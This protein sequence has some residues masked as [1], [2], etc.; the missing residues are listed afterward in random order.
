MKRAIIIVVDSLGVGYM[1]DV[2][3]TR[4]QDIGSNTFKHLLDNAE[5]IDIPNFEKLGINKI[6]KHP[7]LSNKDNM[8]SYGILNL[9]H[10][11]ADSFV[12]QS[13]P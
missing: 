4:P 13:A 12:G 2:P 7:R 11:G 6:L 10:Y 3:E 1:K 8:G 5:K 9:E